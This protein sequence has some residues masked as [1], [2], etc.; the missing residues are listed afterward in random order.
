MKLSI[1]SPLVLLLSTALA[2]PTP[3]SEGSPVARSDATPVKALLPRSSGS[4]TVSGLGTRKKAVT[5]DGGTT[6]DLAIAMLETD[7]MQAT[8]TYG[9]GKTSDSA[10]FG[11]FKQNW[12]MM[13]VCGSLFKGETAAQYNNGAVLNSN[14]GS[15]VSTRHQ[16]QSYYGIDKW[17]GGHRDGATGLSNPYTTDITNYKNAVYWIQSQITSNSKYLTDDTRFW[18]DVVAI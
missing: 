4:Y 10:N 2:A 14:L 9:D 17:F 3:E 1:F 8:Y 11:I 18:V 7:N 15:D 12:G 5:A 16:C 13:R 6:L